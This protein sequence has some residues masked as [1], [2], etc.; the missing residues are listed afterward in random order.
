MATTEVNLQFTP[1]INVQIVRSPGL[2]I[3]KSV[4]AP[5]LVEKDCFYEITNSS[6]ESRDRTIISKQVCL[7]SVLLTVLFVVIGKSA[8]EGYD[9]RR[10]RQTELD[11]SLY[12]REY[13]EM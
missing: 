7:S 11:I 13:V 12:S 6:S 4:E 3:H 9:S 2:P 1:N 5:L 10:D 8:K